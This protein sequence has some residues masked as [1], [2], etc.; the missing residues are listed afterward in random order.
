[1]LP[2]TSPVKLPTNEFEVTVD[3]PEIVAEVLPNDIV[4]DPN[5]ILL[6]D[7]LLLAILPANIVLVT[8]PVS[9]IYTPLVTV[10]ELPVTLPVTL[11]VKFPVTFPVT[12]PTTFPLWVP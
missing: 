8:V 11:P 9:V 3:S 2:T 4:V 10:P 5:V 1:M 12:F 7:N 6:L